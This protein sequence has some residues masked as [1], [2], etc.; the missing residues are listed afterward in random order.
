MMCSVYVYEKHIIE[1]VTKYKFMKNPEV[2]ILN[3]NTNLS[4]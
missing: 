4:K 1:A 3:F 2:K